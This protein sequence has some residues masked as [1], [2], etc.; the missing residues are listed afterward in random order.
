MAAQVKGGGRPV[1]SAIEVRIADPESGALLPP[2]APGE[3]Q[4]RG[5]N[6]L[7]HYLGN[8]DATARAITADGWF[9]TG[10]LASDDGDGCFTYICRNSDAL[11]LRG[12]LV[13]PAEIEQFLM[14]HP[15]VETARVVGVRT[16]HGDAPF[17]FVTLA[18]PSLTPEALLAHC[19]GRLAAFKI[20]VR[21]AVLDAFPV[22]AGT[23]GAKIKTEELKRM[24]QA[25]FDA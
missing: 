17:G 19:K 2:G 6:R 13:E 25:T 23:N 20:P 12:F 21:I 14:S 22:T 16:E 24:A 10:D 7:I 5:Y 9:R 15:G 18:D 1:S 3:L 4:V 11:R 8:P